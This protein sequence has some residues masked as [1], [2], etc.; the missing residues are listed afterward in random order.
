[1]GGQK[2][3]C[4]GCGGLLELTVGGQNGRCMGGGG[5]LELTVGRQNVDI[6]VVVVC[7]S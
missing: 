5:L 4:I 7:W 1:V 6:L 3:R 2:G